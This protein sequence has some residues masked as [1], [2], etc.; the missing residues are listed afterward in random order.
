MEDIA[1]SSPLSAYEMWPLIAAALLFFAG[2]FVK[3]LVGFAL[4][5]VAVPGT[6]PILPAQTAVAAV[7]LPVAVTNLL[8]AFR[9]GVGPMLETLRRFWLLNATLGVMIVVGASLLPGLDDRIFFLII[10]A[11]T[12]SAA[13][14][15]L[16]GWRPRIAAK[17][18]RPSGVVAGGVGG[19]IGGVSGIWGPPVVL[20]L[21]A[22]Q[23]EKAQHFRASGL[24]F[25]VGSLILFPAH[26]TTGV[27]NEETLPLSA[28]M[29]APALLGIV[30]GRYAEAKLDADMFRNAT[31]V[32]LVLASL[33]LLRKALG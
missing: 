10:G 7:I 19:L 33:N 16:L 24:A 14:V 27:L 8:Q 32:V 28:A 5:L 11:V 25:A 3:G 15:Q 20:Y 12:L 26:L 2:G 17:W 22:L 18:E 30:A 23:V 29:V 6:A 31:L 4:P 1:H 9:Q 13:L 21:N